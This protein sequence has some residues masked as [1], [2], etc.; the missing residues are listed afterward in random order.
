MK[1]L[2]LIP[3]IALMLV[4]CNQEAV[5]EKLTP[6]MVQNIETS[7]Q[8][9]MLFG[10]YENVNTV[11]GGS[12]KGCC[13]FDENR[14]AIANFVTTLFEKE[15]GQKFTGRNMLIGSTSNSLLIYIV[16][17]NNSISLAQKSYILEITKET[18]EVRTFR[19]MVE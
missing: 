1:Q 8:Q 13:V 12:Y 6:E 10:H 18:A 11:Y 15:T 17:T 7:N 2:I 16:P 4:A 3:L 14:I 5:N 19:E 9:E